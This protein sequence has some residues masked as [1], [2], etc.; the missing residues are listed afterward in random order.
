MTCCTSVE[1]ARR[2]SGEHWRRLAKFALREY[3]EPDNPRSGV[4]CRNFFLTDRPVQSHLSAETFS[5]CRYRK[6]S[7]A[8]Q[9]A[10][11]PIE[12]LLIQ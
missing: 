1:P 11:M 12:R 2:A 5:A 3:G 10:G 7:T 4:R 8:G 9:G 6:S